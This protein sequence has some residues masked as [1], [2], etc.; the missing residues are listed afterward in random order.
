MSVWSWGEVAACYRLLYG[1]LP[2]DR[3]RY[4]FAL[5]GGIPRQVL[6]NATDDEVVREL[7][8]ALESCDL[9]RCMTYAGK[10]DSAE[11][12]SHRVMHLCLIEGDRTYTQTRI[13]FASAWVAEQLVQNLMLQERNNLLLFL[14]NAAGEGNA[15]SLRG[16][17]FEGYAHSVLRQGGTFRARRILPPGGPPVDMLLPATALETFD[18][19]AHVDLAR[20][21]TYF[22]PVSK[23]LAAVDAFASP[24]LLLQ[25]TV[26]AQHDVKMAGLEHAA[27][28]VPAGTVPRLVFVV[29]PDIFPTFAAQNYVTQRG[30]LAMRVPRAVQDVEQWVLAVP[31]H[32]AV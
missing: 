22:R 13:L 28:C 1:H 4:L 7:N 26:S 16:Q 20:P 10:V 15:A 25:M 5:C 31:L 27:A 3:V 6:Q 12:V 11:D 14:S 18:D 30:T 17:L 29:P 23:S 32:S 21:G 2:A 9:R 19:L 8:H 24:N